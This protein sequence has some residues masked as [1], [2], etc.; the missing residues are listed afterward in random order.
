M[1]AIIARDN[2]LFVDVI[3]WMDTEVSKIDLFSVPDK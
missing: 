2:E 3:Y 1:L